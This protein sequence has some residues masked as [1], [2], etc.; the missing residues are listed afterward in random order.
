MNKRLGCKG[1]SLKPW[2]LYS[3]GLQGATG[4]ASSSAGFG[5]EETYDSIVIRDRSAASTSR[6]V[7]NIFVNK[8][9]TILSNSPIVFSSPYEIF[10]KTVSASFTSNFDIIFLFQYM[11]ANGFYSTFNRIAIGLSNITTS[12]KFLYGSIIGSSVGITNGLYNVAAYGY[13]SLG[14]LLERNSHF[15]VT[16]YFPNDPTNG[17]NPIFPAQIISLKER[18]STFD[19]TD[20]AIIHTIELSTYY[21]LINGV[22]STLN[23]ERGSIVTIKT[24]KLSKSLVGFTSSATSL[25]TFSI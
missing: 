20:P 8:P 11:G 21:E 9:V 7:S 18:G 23:V 19:L 5:V 17:V 14:F 24:R 25:N 6:D 3:Q 12:D 4:A 15:Y 10:N 2:V 13:R 1:I 22:S 16:E